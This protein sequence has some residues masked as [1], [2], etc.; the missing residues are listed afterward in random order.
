MI[1]FVSPPFSDILRGHSQAL[2]DCFNSAL[3]KEDLQREAL[4]ELL[5]KKNPTIHQEKTFQNNFSSLRRTF[6]FSFLA[7][8][9]F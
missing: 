4:H 5:A 8:P 9:K 1:Q 2:A 3:E 6:L 7:Y